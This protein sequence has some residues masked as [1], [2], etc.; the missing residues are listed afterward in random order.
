M[1]EADGDEV[2]ARPGDDLPEEA[3]RDRRGGGGRRH[4]A[5]RARAAGSRRGARRGGV[6]TPRAATFRRLAAVAAVA[7]VTARVLTKSLR[8]VEARVVEARRRIAGPTQRA[9]AR[10]RARV[11]PAASLGNARAPREPLVQTS[12]YLPVPAIVVHQG[13]RH[14]ER[15]G[16]GHREGSRERRGRR[17]ARRDAA[18]KLGV[19]G[20][21]VAREVQIQRLA[22][23]RRAQIRGTR[24]AYRGVLRG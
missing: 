9:R 16:L 23:G 20:G 14:A 21:V 5:R 15:P 3:D 7:G 2:D 22:P 11:A 19:A 18:R 8:N 24:G 6:G 17:D 13:E 4:A 1:L 12:A 10:M